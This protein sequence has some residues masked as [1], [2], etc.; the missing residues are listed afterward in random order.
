MTDIKQQGDL[1]IIDEANNTLTVDSANTRVG[2]GNNSPGH[3]L[4]V[5]GDGNFTANLSA[6][7][8]L[9]LVDAGS[10]SLTVGTTTAVSG[11]VLTV[12]GASNF[13]DTITA[14]G[15]GNSL[16]ISD[17][18]RIAQTGSGLRMT[19]VGAFDND[20]SDN[21]RVFGS[22]DLILAANGETG[23][24]I[25]IDATNQDV[26]VS[27][28]LSITGT[29][30]VSTLTDGTLSISGG[31]ISS[32]TLASPIITGVIAL[33]SNSTTVPP[34]TLTASSLN[35]GVGALRIDSV[36]PDIYLND[37][38]GGFTTVTFANNDTASAAFGRNS[39]DDFYI[40]VTTDGSTWRND[41]FVVDHDTGDIAVGYKFNVGTGDLQ[42][43]GTDI[44][45]TA[46]ELNQ[47][48]GVTLGTAA[49][50]NVGDFATA[51]QG[52]TADTALQ[53]VAVD[54][55]TITG[56]GTPGNPLVAAGG[57]GGIS[58]GD[59]VG[60]GT[61]GSILFVDASTN[62]AQDNGELYWDNTNNRLGIGTTSPSAAIEVDAGAS[63]EYAIL[64]TGANGRV[65][66]TTQY[67]GIHINNVEGTA[68]L[69]QLS[70]RDTAQFDIAFGTPDSGNNVAATDTQF[71]IT[72]GGN[73][74]IGLGSTNPSQK[75]HVSGTIRQTN[76]TSAVL[77][78]DGNGDIGSASNLQDVSY[79]QAQP[80]QPPGPGAAPVIGNWFLP[81]PANFVGWIDIGG[82]FV[83]AFQ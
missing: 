60:S 2:I 27:N 25:T 77:V 28:D 36:E 67:G 59:S 42:I 37:T 34:L 56:D 39:S 21:F 11:N 49:S 76:S 18:L 83:P 74:G 71:R 57:G 7:S 23:T 73:V 8:N 9:F 62:L 31:I 24:A 1:Y 48:D 64:S 72:S 46:T 16:T 43:N 3:S 80:P 68:D 38:N 26:A 13:S 53:I 58:I 12:S 32:S 6:G 63:T 10:N 5:T 70:E 78:S 4:S 20:G 33:N 65:G 66:L 30:N 61:S 55:S 41:T 54:G 14:A 35:D 40:T 75:L 81:S 22:N 44:T 29:T 45:A 79:Y 52:A 51:A 47:L 82:F 50:S 69:W 17:T 15:T 19:N